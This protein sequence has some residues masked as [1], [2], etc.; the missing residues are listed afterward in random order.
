MT[1]ILLC[2]HPHALFQHEPEKKRKM[3]SNRWGR[4]SPYLDFFSAGVMQHAKPSCFKQR[5]E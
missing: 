2:M 5:L 3:K 1:K 4:A